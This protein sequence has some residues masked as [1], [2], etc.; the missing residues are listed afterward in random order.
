LTGGS[1]K[2][3]QI[4]RVLHNSKCANCNH[5]AAKKNTV[6]KVPWINKNISIL[7]VV[8][9]VDTSTPRHV[10]MLTRRRVDVSVRRLLDVSTPLRRAEA[11]MCRRVDPPDYLGLAL[12]QYLTF[13]P[14]IKRVFC[15][16]LRP[17]CVSP[18]CAY[19]THGGSLILTLY[20]L[21]VPNGC[22]EFV[23]IVVL[24]YKRK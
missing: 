14:E 4:S 24:R 6:D 17:C 13:Q 15:L 7:F 16:L 22:I 10:D 20:K 12:L 1:H 21:N 2:S 18:L 19:R 9:G 3:E 23:V 5:Q 8:R 11:S